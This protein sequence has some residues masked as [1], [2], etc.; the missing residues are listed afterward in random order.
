MENNLKETVETKVNLELIND[1]EHS[2]KVVLVMEVWD[3]HG[4]II[5]DKVA[6]K[7]ETPSN[8][9][10]NFWHYRNIE[11]IDFGVEKEMG[12]YGTYQ[13]V[14]EQLGLLGK[15]FTEEQETIGWG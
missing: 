14:K 2:T 9:K 12:A 8:K 6:L 1:I 7:I 13:F 10:G 11:P 15:T 5:P 4:N 3:S